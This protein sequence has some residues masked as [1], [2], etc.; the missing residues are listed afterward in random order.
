MVQVFRLDQ[1]QQVT[2]D[3]LEQSVETFQKDANLTGLVKSTCCPESH[4]GAYADLM[5]ETT[6]AAG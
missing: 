1:E 2:A 4:P 5:S 3:D 6:P